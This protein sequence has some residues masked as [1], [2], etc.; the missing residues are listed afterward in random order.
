[1]RENNFQEFYDEVFRIGSF[2]TSSESPSS[3]SSVTSSRKPRD[4]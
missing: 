4:R 2:V 3:F 1:M